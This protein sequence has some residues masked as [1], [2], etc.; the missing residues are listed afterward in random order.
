MCVVT[1]RLQFGI[2]QEAAIGSTGLEEGSRDFGM[3]FG[4]CRLADRRLVTLKAKPGQAV[5]NGLDGVDGRTL[6]VRI[7]DA[8][9]IS[10]AVMAGE[11][12]VEKRR[13]CPANMQ[14][15]GWGGQNA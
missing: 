8:K 5:M 11:Q 3:A 12:P 14:E 6:A 1:K 4:A 10:A 13:A 9:K 15:T 2:R 7:L